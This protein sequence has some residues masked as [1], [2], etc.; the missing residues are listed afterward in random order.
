MHLREALEI[1]P[2]NAVAHWLLASN[3]SRPLEN[4]SVK[5]VEALLADEQ[6]SEEDRCFL[7]FALASSFDKAGDCDR[8]IKHA[9]QANQL[10]KRQLQLR[11]YRFDRAAQ[12]AFVDEMI[13]LYTPEFFAAER[14]FG[15]ES[16]LPVFIV[17]MPRSGTTVVEQIL[18]SHSQVFGAG[19]LNEM[20]AVHPRLLKQFEAQPTARDEM[21]TTVRSVSQ[22]YLQLLEHLGGSALRV[23]DKMPTNFQYLGM[24]AALYPN[25]HVVH[26]V[27]DRRDVLLSCYFQN[28]SSETLSFA[29]DM[30]DLAAY[31]QEYERLMNHWRSVLP[32]KIHEVSYEQLVREQEQV[33]RELIASCGLCWEAGCL[34]FHKTKRTITTASA[35]QVREPLH[36]QSVARWRR[37][38]PHIDLTRTV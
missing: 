3:D 34:D 16:R 25:A 21:A 19:E 1:E 35:S 4:R 7:H 29:C 8:A 9:H 18:A 6:R 24:I 32:L 31:F 11:G 26:C 20:T 27:R 12:A 30:D 14:E 36:T 38:E 15:N 13:A 28:F 17:G 10:K 33:S 5:K 2:E 22:A 23:I 37:Y